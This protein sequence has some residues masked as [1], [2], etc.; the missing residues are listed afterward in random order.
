MILFREIAPVF[1]A[2]KYEQQPIEAPSSVTVITGEEI[3]SQGYRT[4]ADVLR[5]VR[6]VFV[7]YDRNYSYAGIRGF[8]RPGD[9]NS[10]VLLLVDGL[11]VNDNIYDSALIG[12]EFVL[13]LAL[14]SR[15][16]VVRG[17][18]SSLYGS[19]AFFAVINVLTKRGRDLK[20]VEVSAEG[21]SFGSWGG[22]A[23]YGTRTAG[24]VEFLIS[25]TTYQSRGQRHFYP[26]FVGLDGSD[27]WTGKSDGD[28]ARKL[29]LKASWGDFSLDGAFNSRKKEIPT[30]SFGTDF[31]SNS[32]STRDDLAF[33]ALGFEHAFGGERKIEGRLSYNYY[34]YRGDYPS[35]GVINRDVS[36]GRWLGLEW[37]A[38]NPLGDHQKIVTGF[39]L[40]ENIQQDQD[41]FDVEPRFVYLDS[42]NSSR[43]WALFAQD[44]IRLGERFIVNAG[45]RHDNY[46]SFGGTTNPRLAVIW[47]TGEQTAI[48]LLLGR[49]FRAPSAYERFYGT[50]SLQKGNPEIRPETIQSAELVLESTFGRFA[51]TGAFY[52][53]RVRNLISLTEDPSDGILQYQNVDRVEATGLEL[54]LQ[55]SIARRVDTRI[56]YSL[57]ET[58]NGMTGERL[59]NSPR[60]LAKLSLSSRF[61]NDK[62]TTSLEAQ[63]TSSTLAVRGGTTGASAIGN[64]G[65]TARP[66]RAGLEFDAWIYNLTGERYFYSGSEEH[67]QRLIEQDGRT[68]R[69]GIRYGF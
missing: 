65:L 37:S 43:S 49:A 26:E 8:S 25:G 17:P 30:A 4:L 16:E 39:E 23:S 53:Y 58:R 42:D 41:N 66:W 12:T 20:G 22:S 9:Y 7:T 59:T 46:D 36:N 5:S 62:L 48:K 34:Y 61:F 67:L 21:G 31:G 1:G 28:E 68:Y 38:V 24:G 64:L 13:D 2:S 54:E 44:E 40:R 14:V 35:A 11:R 63:F 32:E 3:R 52:H 15:I 10:R 19:N 47:R 45:V 50:G 51:A 29:F 18:S 33:V 69:V 56:S 55:G 60:N 6:G 27:G 57:Q